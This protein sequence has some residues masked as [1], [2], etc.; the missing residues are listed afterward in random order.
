[1]IYRKIGNQMA[2]PSVLA[3]L[4]LAYH[5]LGQHD[6]AITHFHEA[7]T[8]AREI[9]LRYAEAEA[10]WGLGQT[11]HAL[12]RPDQARACWQ[13]AITILREIGMLTEGE[14]EKLRSQPIPDTPEIIER[15]T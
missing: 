6:R 3:N 8:G 10:L 5:R 11:Q 7:L 14:A 9:G 12:G 4:A 2:E 1:M 13:H 15:N